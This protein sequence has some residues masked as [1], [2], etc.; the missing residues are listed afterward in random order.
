M[1]VKQ[2]LKSERSRDAIL[3]AAGAEKEEKSA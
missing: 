1:R 2:E 3:E